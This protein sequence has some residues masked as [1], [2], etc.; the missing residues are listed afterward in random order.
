[1]VEGDKVKTCLSAFWP[2]KILYGLKP[3]LPAGQG[4]SEE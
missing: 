2:L 1:M 3:K 4:M